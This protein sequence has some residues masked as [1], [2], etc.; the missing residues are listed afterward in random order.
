M[1]HFKE[2]GS[3]F[4][5]NIKDL[6]RGEG[7]TAYL[8]DDIR[9]KRAFDNSL[10]VLGVFDNQELIGFIR[11]VGDGEHVVIIQDIIIDAEHK[12]QGLGRELMNLVFEKYSSVR[13]IQLNTDISDERANSFY[14]SLGMKKI[15]ETGAISYCR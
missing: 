6:Y 8:N 11:C 14:R 12:R 1:I 3:E 4:L 2:I 13:W 5:E 10:Y 7:W 9:L 15:E